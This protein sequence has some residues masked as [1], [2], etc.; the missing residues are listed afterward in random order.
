MSTSVPPSPTPRT[1]RPPRRSAT[2]LG[3]AVRLLRALPPRVQRAALE[4]SGSGE[5]PDVPDLVRLL[6]VGGGFPAFGAS[7]DELFA[8]VPAL[9]AVRVSQP[10]IEGPAGRVSA[11]LYRPPGAITSRDALVWVHGGA[12]LFGEL[13]MA[14]AHWVGLALAERGIPVLSLDY[15][16]SIGGVHAPAS[17]D[18]V[19]AGWRWATAHADELGAAVDRLHLGGASA[20]GNLAAGVGLRLR[21]G[22]GPLPTSLVLV[23]PLLHAELPNPD[24]ELLDAVR[25]APNAVYFSPE[26]IADM[27]LNHV[28][29]SAALS[30]PY[31]FPA[32]SE[33]SGLPRTLILNCEVDTLRSSGEAYAEQLQRAGVDVTVHLEPGAGHGCLNEPFTTHGQNSLGRVADWLAHFAAQDRAGTTCAAGLSRPASQSTDRD[34]RPRPR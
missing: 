9:R 29:D 22:A 2:F 31:A 7:E 34:P 12:F 33:A 1:L 28:G 19:L 15:R 4:R 5:F 18:D 17:S 6:D 27:T 20:G 23:Y 10:L 24:A 16:K 14:E 26:W 11:R 8:R 25:A 21:D 3:L 13:G 30:D 32:N